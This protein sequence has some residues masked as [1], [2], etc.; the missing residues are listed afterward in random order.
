MSDFSDS[1]V[2]PGAEVEALLGLVVESAPNGI[3]VVDCDG[4]IVHANRK[5][6]QLLGYN[7]AELEELSVEDLIPERLREGH[8]RHREKYDENPE[9]RAMGAG[10][11]LFARRKDGSEFPVEIGLTPMVT[12]SGQMTVASIIDISARKEAERELERQ[13]LILANVHDAVFVVDLDGVVQSW[14]Q[15]AELV[16]GF[17]ERD[18]VGTSVSQLLPPD[19]GGRFQ[20]QTLPRV[21][22]E[23]RSNFVV[24]CHRQD[25]ARIAVSIRASVLENGGG[26]AEGL[27]ICANDITHQR[28]LEQKLLEVSESEQRRIG[29][30][31][32]DD[33]C[34]QL[35]SIGCLTKVLE[36]KLA[37]IYQEGASHLAQIGDMVSQANVRA[38]EIVKG[39]V[40][41][42]L[43]SEG[44]KGALAELAESTARAYSLDCRFQCP[45]P[46]FLDDKH[47]AVQLFRIAQ[48]AVGN[49]ARHSGATRIDIWLGLREGKLILRIS[50]NG[51][52]I[53]ESSDSTGLGL[54][55]MAHRAQIL[56]GEFDIHSGSKKG[57]RIECAI[58]HQN[59]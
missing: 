46:V 51:A 57:T 49:A 48:E 16:F 50:D 19:D 18:I 6:Q 58:P 45:D 24:W 27:I 12:P 33:L 15:G 5:A 29:A 39:L 1:P 37:T 28:E 52:G 41:A 31:I 9:P 11:D 35:A 54:L 4:G 56:G 55:T 22:S 21:V 23:R 26:D 42:V 44:L 53:A 43:E 13:A 25:G 17:A 20:K 30:D 14:N 59:D 34:Q 2:G 10:R 36:Q 40:P 8:H 47:I 38:R 3:I 32:H 7:R